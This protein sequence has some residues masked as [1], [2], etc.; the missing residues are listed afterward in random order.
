[1]GPPQHAEEPPGRAEHPV[2]PQAPQRASQQIFCPFEV[3]GMPVE[4][5]GSPPAATAVGLWTKMV[6]K[7]N[8]KTFNP[9]RCCIIMTFPIFFI[10]QKAP[11]KPIRKDAIVIFMII[12]MYVGK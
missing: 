12:A 9:C 8:N 3:L 5:V 6:V 1:M 7:V 2:P 11:P 4:Q 10:A